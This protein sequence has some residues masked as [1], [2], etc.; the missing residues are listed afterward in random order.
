MLEISQN[1]IIQD[2]ELSFKA[3]RASGPGG[4]HVNTTSSAVQLRFDAA[5]SPAI[6][7]AML[8][9]LKAAAGRRMDSNGVLTLR[10]ESHSSQHRNKEEAIERLSSL[11][12]TV[13]KPK[14]YRVK[15]KPSKA[16]NERRLK[17]KT[18]TKFKK[19]SRGKVSRHH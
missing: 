18:Q 8:Q 1:I 10:A 2:E 11:L 12:R 17:S 9:R 3:V 7:P 14:K 6:R 16:S 19:Q 13:E 4:Q 15:T 5:S